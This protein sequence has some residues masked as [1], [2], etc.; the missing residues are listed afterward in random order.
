M[1]NFL[2]A[3]I[4]ILNNI[5]YYDIDAFFVIIHKYMVIV[6]NVKQLTNLMNGKICN[7]Y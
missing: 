6:L 2:L 1:Q 7:T 4:I 5:T 3:F